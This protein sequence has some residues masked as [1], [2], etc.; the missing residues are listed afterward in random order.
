M[1]RVT[2][3]VIGSLLLVTGT[4][5]A[6]D[7]GDISG[8]YRYL[9]SEGESVS[10]GFYVD[11]TGHLTNVFSIV[12]EVGGSYKS[13]SETAFGI[14]AE[15]SGRIHTFAA[16]VKL[17]VPFGATAGCAENND[18]LSLLTIKSTVWSSSGSPSLMAFA[19]AAE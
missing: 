10:K 18:G 17:S 12:G 16:G 8:G 4:A 2:A 14:T 19:Q 11:V 5:L 1:R 13:E 3:L 6:Q 9:R 15:A 7:R